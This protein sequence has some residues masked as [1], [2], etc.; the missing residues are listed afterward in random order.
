MAAVFAAYYAAI[1][2]RAAPWLR[3]WQSQAVADRATSYEPDLPGVTVG[4]GLTYVQ[5]RGAGQV[6]VTAARVGWVSTYGDAADDP[7]F[8][9]GRI[10]PLVQAWWRRQQY[11]FDPQVYAKVRGAVVGKLGSATEALTPS[12]PLLY[13]H[14]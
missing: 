10:D 6:A 1:E 9:F 3:L 5:A 4:T 11:L 8:F 2:D 12:V 14:I 7:F 13:G